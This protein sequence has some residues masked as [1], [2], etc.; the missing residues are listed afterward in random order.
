M[1]TIEDSKKRQ[2]HQFIKNELKDIVE[3]DLRLVQPRMTEY[4]FQAIIWDH[5]CRQVKND[6]TLSIEDFIPGTQ[7]KADVVIY[8]CKQDG[9]LDSRYGA[10][11]IEV[12]PNGEI[13][14]IQKDI[15]KLKK[16]TRHA[17]STVNFGVMIYMTRKDHSESRVNH[18]IEKDEDNKKIC[19][20]RINPPKN[21]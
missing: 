18:Y 19:V 3:K 20:I 10:V 7:L 14:G 13:K 5:I 15:K 9:K 8:K 17:E 6:W 2:L 1:S 12:K 4:T 21:F 11:A 16:Y